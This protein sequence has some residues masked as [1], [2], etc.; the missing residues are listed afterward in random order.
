MNSILLGPA[1]FIGT[2]ADCNVVNT[3]VR[4]CSFACAN[5]TCRVVI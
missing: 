1:G 2:V 3:G 5:C 4:S